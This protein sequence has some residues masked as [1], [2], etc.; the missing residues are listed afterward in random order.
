[1]I[2]SSNGLI[3]KEAERKDFFRFL[4]EKNDI[5]IVLGI[6]ILIPN[7]GTLDSQYLSVMSQIEDLDEENLEVF[8]Q[9]Q[10]LSQDEA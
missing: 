5:L 2:A 3:E 6:R 10:K 7:T 1:M 8:C 9:I 4:K